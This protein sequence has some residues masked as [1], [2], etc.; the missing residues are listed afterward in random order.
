MNHAERYEYLTTKLSSM[1]QRGGGL[2][3]S[4][5][6][7]LYLMASHPS[8]AEKIER[9]FSPD[10]I[11]FSGLMKKEEF[12]Y[13]WMKTTADAARNLFSWNS[14]CAA[15]PFE[16]SRMP[17]QAIRNLYT[18]FF[19]ANGDYEVSVREGENGKKEFVFDT[20]AGQNRE[21]IYQQFERALD[22]MGVEPD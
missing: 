2:D 15:T 10:G 22:N 17:A 5:Q 7:A 12:D 20:S 8:L 9:Y 21:L 11:N 14:K 3:C 4:Y 18:S 6:A 13:D 1:R 16:I 19:I